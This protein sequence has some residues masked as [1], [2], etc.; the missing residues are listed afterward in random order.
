MTLDH[1]LVPSGSSE[2]EGADAS[3]SFGAREQKAEAWED[4]RQKALDDPGPGWKEWFLYHGAKMWVALGFFIAD[5]WIFLTWVSAFNAIG[6]ALSIAAAIY[7][8]IL[9]YRYLWYRVNPEAPRPTEPFRRTWL[10]PRE[11]GLWTPEGAMAK[12]G[13]IPRSGSGPRREDFL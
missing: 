8:E 3:A 10:R 2:P 5:M 4:A 12:R 11:F 1:P 9:A 6:L 13:E 7:L